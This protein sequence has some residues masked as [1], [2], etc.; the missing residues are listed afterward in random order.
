VE[1]RDLLRLNTD[2]L[3]LPREQCTSEAV[4]RLLHS[5]Q[6]K[7]IASFSLDPHLDL[8]DECFGAESVEE[9]MRKLESKAKD[10]ENEFAREQL[11]ALTKMV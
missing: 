5:L 9:I 8:I 6:P 3:C 1:S 11:E 2:I 7:N 4:R 10:D